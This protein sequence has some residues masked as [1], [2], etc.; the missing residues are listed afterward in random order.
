MWVRKK[1]LDPFLTNEKL[2]LAFALIRKPNGVAP[3]RIIKN[4]R[5]CADC[6]VFMKF[7]SIT[8]ARPI[9]MRDSNRFHHFFGAKCS[10]ND[11]W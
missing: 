9:I 2:A 7:A 10:C 1:S 3:I 5:V 11:N 4:V 8:I 6:H